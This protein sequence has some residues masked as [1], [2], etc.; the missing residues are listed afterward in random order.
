[1]NEPAREMSDR[2]NGHIGLKNIRNLGR[3]L[4]GTPPATGGH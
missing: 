3:Q 1:M 4:A 2:P